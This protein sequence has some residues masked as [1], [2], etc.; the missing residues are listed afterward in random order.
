MDMQITPSRL[1]GDISLPISKSILHRAIICAALAKG[2]ST[3]GPVTPSVDVEATVGV[4]RA[5]GCR[6]DADG[7]SLT[8]YG[9]DKINKNVTADCHESGSTLRF[10]IPVFA[11]LTENTTFV[12]EGRLPERPLDQYDGII[13]MRYIKKNLPLLVEGGFKTNVF[14]MPGNVSSQFITGLLFALP[15]TG[16]TIIIDG[17]LQSK[18]YIDITIDVMQKFGVTVI[19]KDY[20]EFTTTG[21]Y[22]PCN[23]K[24]QQDFSAAAFWLVAN[25][26][27]NNVNCVGLD[28]D[29]KQG[30]AQIAEI[31]EKEEKIIDV[32]DIPDLGPILAVLGALSDGEMRIVNASRLKIKES[33]RIEAITTGL[34]ALG[35]DIEAGEDEIRVCGKC[36]LYGGV[37]VSSYNDHRIAMSL[38]IAAT[39]C[40]NPVVIEGAECVT[41]SYPDFWNDYKKLGGIINELNMG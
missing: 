25:K 21:Q 11:A 24:S 28:Y 38:A 30:D 16:G 36:E 8:I 9:L 13:N 10:L 3:V 31:I 37:N 27:G 23:F 22:T 12:G 15:I 14:T 41:K 19:N 32:S 6:I 34:K 2:K 4:V 33:D 18:P 1:S 35:A 17:E 5:L 40:K 20:K 7:D 26:L 39:K 29:T